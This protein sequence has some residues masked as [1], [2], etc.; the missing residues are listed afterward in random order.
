VGGVVR[1]VITPKPHVVKIRWASSEDGKTV[2]LIFGR[3]AMIRIVPPSSIILAGDSVGLAKDSTVSALAKDITF[4]GVLKASLLNTSISANTNILPSPISPTNSPATFRIYVAFNALGVLSVVR[5][6]GTT[7][8]TE[9]LNGGNALN[10]NASY[11][12]DIIVE[13][14]ESINLQY[15][16]NAT[17]LV[18]KVIEV[19]GVI[20]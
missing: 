2:V 4:K 18:L 13:S 14:G 5:T 8:V 10:A 7:T 19:V 9:Q 6:K 11:V 1:E 3:E 15:S 20:G 17:L 16:V 12:F